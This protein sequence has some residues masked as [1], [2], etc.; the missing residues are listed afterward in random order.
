MRKRDLVNLLLNNSLPDV[1]VL[2]FF[3]T[4]PLDGLQCVIL[5]FP[6]YTHYFYEL[7]RTAKST[8]A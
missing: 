8:L 1:S 4:V 2:L 3:L 6:G 7:H 5:V